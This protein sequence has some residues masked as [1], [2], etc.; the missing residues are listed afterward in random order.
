[1][2]TADAEEYTQALGQVVA[3]GW[4]QV[5][6][7]ERL[8]VPKALGLSTRDWVQD[9]LGGYV[10]LSIPERREAVAEL[11]EEGMSTREIGAV[12][13]VDKQTVQRDRAPVSDETPE[14]LAEPEPQVEPEPEPEPVSD[15]TPEPREPNPAVTE[16]VESSQAI[17]DAA[18]L[19]EFWKAV[20]RSHAYM[21]FDPEKIGRL[22]N[23]DELAG[24]R[25]LPGRAERWA[26]KA[27]QASSGLRMI[28]GGSP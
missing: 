21:E 5:A 11:T 27:L 6:L 28:E 12:L 8:G 20:V 9:R 15:E 10:R 22:A 4:R 1:V 19:H 23:Q 25:E 18:Y 17:K 26:A 24:I 7:G 2:N 14:P 3:G 13:G 16:W